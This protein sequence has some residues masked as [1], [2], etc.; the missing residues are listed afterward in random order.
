MSARQPP[1][2]K[3]STSTERK[4]STSTYAGPSR[5]RV[6]SASIPENE[7]RS[8]TTTHTKRQSAANTASERRTDR[9]QVLSRETVTART[10][11]P[12]K[13]TTESRVNARRTRD[14][15]RLTKPAERASASSAGTKRGNDETKGM[16]WCCNLALCNYG[17][18]SN[19]NLR[20]AMGPPSFSYTSH[21]STSC[22]ADICTSSGIIS[23]PVAPASTAEPAVS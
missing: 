20:S 1:N 4:T 18:I 13:H 17:A 10:R 6:P 2:L 12:L 5:P 15:E 14:T 7:R 9:T 16:L 19:C 8:S 23:S 21:N 22:V 3:S 11:S